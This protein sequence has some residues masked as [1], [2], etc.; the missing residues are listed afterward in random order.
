[1]GK[2]C[3]DELMKKATGDVACTPDD[4]CSSPWLTMIQLVVL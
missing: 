4:T 3:S 1:M 2:D